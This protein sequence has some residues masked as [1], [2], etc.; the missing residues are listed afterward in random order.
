MA[1]VICVDDDGPADYSSIQA[2]I[3]AAVS[4]SD[5]IVIRRGTYFEHIDLHGKAV[6]VRSTDPLDPAVVESTVIDGGAT[7]TVVTCRSG[8]GPDTVLSGLTSANGR[9]INLGGGMAIS[10][11]PRVIHCRIVQNAA[12]G[13]GAGVTVASS[14]ASP[15]FEYCTFAGNVASLYGGGLYVEDGMPTLVN[16]TFVGNTAKRGGGIELYGGT[17]TLINCQFI[18]N[19]ASNYGGGIH[20]Y[21]RYRYSADLKNCVFVGNHAGQYGGA[22][23]SWEAPYETLIWVYMTNCTFAGNGAGTGGRSIALGALGTQGVPIYELFNCILWEEDT[24][25]VEHGSLDTYDSDVMGRANPYTRVID[26]DPLFVRNPAPGPDGQWGTSDDDHGDLRLQPGSPCIDAGNN[27]TDPNDHDGDGDTSELFPIDL[28]GHVRRLDDPATPDC[29]YA[30]G[31]CGTAPIV[32]MGAYEFTPAIPGDFD[33]DGDVDG[34]DLDLLVAC[35]SGPA[36]LFGADCDAMDLDGDDDVDQS[37]FG[38]FQRGYSGS[39]RPA[40]PDCTARR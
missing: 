22:A 7:G 8:E 19:Y 30:P 5:E 6:T 37:D 10:G 23:A 36:I 20:L 27:T 21:S 4:G 32:D 14:G 9:H 24:I 11:S 25:R 26:A 15:S 12:Y 39:S 29:R 35:T 2:A 38:L 16:C 40:D 3:D 18:Q 17:V 34:H 28:D 1:A 13:R 31:A 33:H